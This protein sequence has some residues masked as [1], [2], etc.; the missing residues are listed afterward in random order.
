MSLIHKETV[1]VWS[2]VTTRSLQ[3]PR[4]SAYSSPAEFPIFRAV[5]TPGASHMHRYEIDE[6]C[7]RPDP[8]ESA[9]RMARRSLAIV[10]VIL[11]TVALSALFAS[12]A[13]AQTLN[14]R[15]DTTTAAN[16]QVTP[17]LTWSTTPVASSCVASGDPA[18]TGTK[19]ASGTLALPA[20]G[21]PKAYTLAC[22][23]PGSTSVSLRWVAATTNTDGSAYTNPKGTLI[24]FGTSAAALTSS[25]MVNQP[26]ATT[27]TV[28][29]L[30]PGTYFFCVK[31]VNA[32]DMQSECSNVISHTLAAA[33][34]ITQTVALK[35]PSAPTSLA[36]EQP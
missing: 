34:N 36:V 28:T 32:T 10:M 27:A 31:H 11:L 8:S 2:L 14:L 9:T 16:G 17:A 35:K 33:A 13:D 20:T 26:S 7:P 30:T 3:S 24:A 23:F 21:D 25:R 18:W 1:V 12:R 15:L 22:A 19:A 6:N 29:D 5:F 4:N